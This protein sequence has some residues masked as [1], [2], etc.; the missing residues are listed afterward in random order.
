MSEYLFVKSGLGL[1][2]ATTSDILTAKAMQDATGCDARFLTGYSTEL[3]HRL[4]EH[5]GVTYEVDPTIDRESNMLPR[6]VAEAILRHTGDDTRVITSQFYSE[7]EAHIAEAITTV[8]ERK[9]TAVRMHNAM[10]AAAINM[11]R[12]LPTETLALPIHDFMA[13]RMQYI[14]EHPTITIPPV[15][16]PERFATS[17]DKEELA[18]EVRRSYDIGVDDILLVQPTSIL[19]RKGPRTSLRLAAAIKEQLGRETHLLLS[20]RPH[21]HESVREMGRVVALGIELDIDCLINGMSRKRRTDRNRVRDLLGAASLAAMPSYQD[22]VMLTIPESALTRTPIFTRAYRDAEG[23]PL[24]DSIY[25]EGLEC[26]VQ[27]DN[28][29]EPSPEVIRQACE[30]ISGEKQFNLD[31]NAGFASQF[32]PQGITSKLRQIH[33]Y[34]DSHS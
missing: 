24:F 15:F 6:A 14:S 13:R 4:L 30:V 28:N 8:A 29:E 33:D 10:G 21:S 18:R 19:E 23:D 9:P 25:R 12:T 20:A 5:A 17:P 3:S 32:T 1:G 27:E 7:Q 34:F 31:A 11:Y 22:D 26:I 2:G 16:D